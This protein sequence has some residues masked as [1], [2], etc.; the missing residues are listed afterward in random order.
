MSPFHLLVGARG[1]RE[2][3]RQREGGWMPFFV[4]LFQLKHISFFIF[5]FKNTKFR[6]ESFFECG[7]VHGFLIHVV[8]LGGRLFGGRVTTNAVAGCHCRVTI[9][10]HIFL[11]YSETTTSFVLNFLQTLHGSLH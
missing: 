4:G 8:F 7:D 5:V 1:R 3:D 2:A 11:L 9:L 6:N 10:F